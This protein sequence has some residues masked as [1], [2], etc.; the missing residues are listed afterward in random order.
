MVRNSSRARQLKIVDCHLVLKMQYAKRC[1]TFRTF[2]NSRLHNRDPGFYAL[3]SHI[4]CKYSSQRLGKK[5]YL[6]VTVSDPEFG[7][8]K[9]S[10]DISMDLRVNIW[11]DSDQ[12]SCFFPHG[13]CC[14]WDI[15]QIKLTVTIYEYSLLNCKFEFFW[16]LPVTI[17]NSPVIVIQQIQNVWSSSNLKYPISDPYTRESL[18]HSN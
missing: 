3:Q 11:I 1:Q 13:F 17:E 6:Q 7:V 2:S 15:L 18:Y 14:C 5:L 8:C 10:G 16:Q 12:N 9:P 4:G